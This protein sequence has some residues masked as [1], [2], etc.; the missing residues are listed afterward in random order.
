MKLKEGREWKKEGGRNHFTHQLLH[1]F[2]GYSADDTVCPSYQ[3]A[4]ELSALPLHQITHSSMMVHH[5]TQLHQY[6]KKC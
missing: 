5:K 4:L 1:Y 6:A 2:M 3:S